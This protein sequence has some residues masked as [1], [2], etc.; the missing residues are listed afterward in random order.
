MD[1]NLEKFIQEVNNSGI[2]EQLISRLS[3]INNPETSAAFQRFQDIASKYNVPNSFRDIA[4]FLRY[5]I[6]SVW[7]SGAAEAGA[8][9]AQ[10]NQALIEA[11]K[12]NIPVTATQTGQLITNNLPVTARSVL[13]PLT[14]SW[15]RSQGGATVQEVT[16]NPLQKKPN[17]CWNRPPL[18]EVLPPQ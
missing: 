16:R 8:S 5:N 14:T 2:I 17:D 15:V 18:P 3:G 1:A 7:A 10:I 13:D 4:T 6:N 12:N 11:A 9:S